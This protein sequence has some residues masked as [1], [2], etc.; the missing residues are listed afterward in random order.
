[1]KKSAA[2]KQQRLASFRDRKRLARMLTIPRKTAS[3]LHRQARLKEVAPV[4]LHLTR[5]G[6]KIRRHELTPPEIL[7]LDENYSE[8][9]RFLQNLRFATSRRG[10]FHIE[11]MGVKDISPA[12]ALLLVAECD[13]WREMTKS[14]WLRAESVSGWEPSVRRRLKEMGFFTVLNT[15]GPPDDPFVA[16]EDRY[17]PFLTGTRNPGGPAVRLQEEIEALGPVVADPDSLYEGLVEAMTNVAQHA[18][19]SG[20]GE[21]GPKRWW[22][23]ASVNAERHSMTVMVVD[24]GVGIAK[25]LPRSKVWEKIRKALPLEMLKDD[26]EILLAAFTK[27]GEYKSQT[28]EEH[29]G[30]GLRENI[31]GYVESHNSRGQLRVITNRAGYTYSR[32][33]DDEV[34]TSFAVPVPFDGTFIEWVIEDYGQE[35]NENN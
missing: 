7:D 21:Y 15:R 26:A 10:N 16:G 34:E 8:T 17:V 3:R 32:N 4:K 23:S 11:M 19:S 6:K 13:R 31:K 14:K 18:Y 27:G 9:I 33:N 28:G 5:L 30:K 24:H 29:R 22:I 35:R 2:W 25:T 20:N 12:A 1:M